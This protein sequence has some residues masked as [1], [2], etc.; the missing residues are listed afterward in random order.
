MFCPYGL[1]TLAQAVRWAASSLSFLDASLWTVRLGTVS[2][3]A[4]SGESKGFSWRNSN[5]TKT[6][7]GRGEDS[8]EVKTLLSPCLLLS[9]LLKITRNEPPALLSFVPICCSRQM[10]LT[11]LTPLCHEEKQKPASYF[12][13]LF[14]P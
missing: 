11:S 3:E 10:S 5:G 4:T 12:L 13:S 8:A 1:P 2:S 9:F 14:P 7:A 6:V